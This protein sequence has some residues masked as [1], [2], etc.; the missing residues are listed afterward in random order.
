MQQSFWVDLSAD[1]MNDLLKLAVMTTSNISIS[2]IF[3]SGSLLRD[4]HVRRNT[5]SK[6]F[7]ILVIIYVVHPANCFSFL[8]DA[9]LEISCLP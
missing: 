3:S 9:T 5:R 6:H 1:L 7:D 4:L 8:F 2:N